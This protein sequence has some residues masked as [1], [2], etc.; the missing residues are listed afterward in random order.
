MKKILKL[1]TL[2]LLTCF[3]VGCGGGGGEDSDSGNDAP[4]KMPGLGITAGSVEGEVFRFPDGVTVEGDVSGESAI[5][6]D[7]NTPTFNIKANVLEG[8]DTPNFDIAGTPNFKIVDVLDGSYDVIRG[9]GGIYV[10]VTFDLRNANNVNTTVVFPAGFLA[11]SIGG[12][13][14]HG[15][16]LKETSI[17]IPA[18]KKIKVALAL[19]CANLGIPGSAGYKYDSTFKVLTYHTFQELFDLVANKKINIEEYEKDGES[20]FNIIIKFIYNWLNIEYKEDNSAS[21][22]YISI[23]KRLNQAIWHI[24]NYDYGNGLTDD[25]RAYIANLPNSN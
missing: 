23:V 17:D 3:L 9:S 15:L 22:T 12:Q 18:N 25:D 16:L 11:V 20:F 2:V 1:F 7:T 6:T 10:L 13:A 21:D 4:G 5:Y 8:I 24:V 19:Y 14:Q